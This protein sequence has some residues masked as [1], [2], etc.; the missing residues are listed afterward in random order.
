MDIGESC[1]RYKKI[2]DLPVKLIG[3]LVGRIP[4]ENF[5]AN[6]E[7]PLALSKKK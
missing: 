7:S 3:K 4:V 6:Y 1:V 5:I 2:E